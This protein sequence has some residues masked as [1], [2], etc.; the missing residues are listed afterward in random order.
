MARVLLA[1][2]SFLLIIS[3]NEPVKPSDGDTGATGIPAPVMLTS[4]IDSIFPHD[5]SA[6]TQGLQ[7]VNGKLLEGTGDFAN[8]TIRIVDI[9]TGKP[10]RMHKMGTDDIFGEG[11]TLLHDTVYQLTWESHVAYVYHIKDLTK[12]IK[13]FKWPNEG[14]GITHDGTNLMISDGTAN[15][16]FV[17]PKDFSIIRKIT[18]ADNTGNIDRLNELEY[19]DGFIWANVYQTD[20]ILKIDPSNGHVVGKLG[21]PNLIQTYDAKEVTNR[22]DVLNGIAYDSATKC[23]YITGKRWPKL[24]R[25]RIN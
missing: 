4:T 16:Y 5:T 3:C 9:K 24:F 22:T 17:S 18:V 20:F 19:V 6:Y 13:T 7:F 12:P 21:L 11:V 10:E 1:A 14:W 8:S 25:M 2:L 15:I 23:F